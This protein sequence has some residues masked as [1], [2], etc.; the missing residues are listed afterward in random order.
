MGQGFKERG[1]SARRL[2]IPEEKIPT[3]PERIVKER[4][5]FLLS[6]RFE[7]DQEVPA[8]HEI[9]TGKRRIRKEILFGEDDVL[10]QY[11]C[12]G[13]RSTIV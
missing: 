2:G 4:D 3:R 7:I 9:E 12:D 5:A 8:D 11:P 13:D 1:L 6:V 10:P